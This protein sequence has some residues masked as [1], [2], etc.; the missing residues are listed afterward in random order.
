MSNQQL[1]VAQ[2]ASVVT[3][4]LSLLDQILGETKI[5][6]NDEGYDVAR[7]GV[8][9]AAVSGGAGRAGGGVGGPAMPSAPP[10]G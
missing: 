6:P 3:T 10:P 8:A 7:R 9:A 2:D 1:E 4:E 5:Q